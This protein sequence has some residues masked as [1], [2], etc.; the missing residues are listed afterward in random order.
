MPL[1]TRDTS[2]ETFLIMTSLKRITLPTRSWGRNYDNFRPNKNYEQNWTH[3]IVDGLADSLW[4]VDLDTIL[5][6][7]EH[8][9]T[10]DETPALAGR[11]D[12]PGRSH[13]ENR[14]GTTPGGLMRH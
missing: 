13:G 11:G 12:R 4:L 1:I 10:F 3:P 8:I 5:T 14:N 7:R 2:G 6:G 9:E